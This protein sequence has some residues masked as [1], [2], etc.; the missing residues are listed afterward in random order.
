M[1]ESVVFSWNDAQTAADK[2]VFAHTDKHLSDIEVT[3]LSASWEGKTYDQMAE[4]YGY[5]TEYLNKDI[6][7]KLWRKLSQA[8]GERVTKRNFREA[9]R[10]AYAELEIAKPETPELETAEPETDKNANSLEKT[11]PTA[12]ASSSH[13]PTDTKPKS[14]PNTAAALPFP[15]G[16]VALQSPFYL[17]RPGVETLCYQTVKQPGALIRIKAPKLMGKTSLMNRILAEAN[18]NVGPVVYLD[19]GNCARALLK[20]LDKFLRRLCAITTQKLGLENKVNDY[21]DTDILGSNDNCTAYFEEYLLPATPAPITLGLDDIDRLFPYP[22]MAEDVLGMLRCWHEKGKVSPLWQRL[23]LVI[24]HSTEV[25]IPL[26]INQSPFNAGVPIELRAFNQEQVAQLA[27]LHDLALSAAQIEILTQRV[28]GHPYLIRLAL[29]KLRVSPIPLE[30]LLQNAASESGIYIAHLRRYLEIVSRSPELASALQQVV[31]AS[32]PV[33]LGSIQ[34]YKLRSMGLIHQVD[35][36][37]TPSCSLYQDYF[38][39]VLS[40]TT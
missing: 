27:Q 39:R 33:E 24:A 10:R 8:L 12:T 15:E 35:N 34:T 38:R 9:L 13:I 23:H 18:E 11:A 32:T 1:P 37:V 5:S 3:V 14:S 19:L 30:T 25:Y 29:Y 21:W 40:I 16:A 17:T 28:G 22:E 20:D 2:T 6:G 4:Q 7:N 31:K 36:H 26:D